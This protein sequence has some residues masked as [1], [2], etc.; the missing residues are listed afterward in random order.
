[1]VSAGSDDEA[2]AVVSTPRGRADNAFIETTGLR[3]QA[4]PHARH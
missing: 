1:M 4:V 3:S 2:P